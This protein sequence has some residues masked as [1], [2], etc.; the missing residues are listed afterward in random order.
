MR[1]QTSQAPMERA[2]RAL[3]TL[4]TAGEDTEVEDTLEVKTRREV[5]L[6]RGHII[7]VKHPITSIKYL[8]CHVHLVVHILGLDR[9]F[10][11]SL[12]SMEYVDYCRC[13]CCFFD[14][15]D[16]LS[17]QSLGLLLIIN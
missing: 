3:S 13:E 8:A 5:I 12:L 15:F 4:L 14:T 16:Y 17:V 10:I 11:I 6:V 9:S 1:L 2:S 7:V